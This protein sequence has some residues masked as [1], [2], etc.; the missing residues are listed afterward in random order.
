MISPGQKL[1]FLCQSFANDKGWMKNIPAVISRCW[2]GADILPVQVFKPRFESADAWV[3]FYTPADLV[4]SQI[5]WEDQVEPAFIFYMLFQRIVK[6][7]VMGTGKRISEIMHH[8]TRPE[9]ARKSIPKAW[10]ISL[11]HQMSAGVITVSLQICGVG[12]AQI[13]EKIEIGQNISQNKCKCFGLVQ[14]H[15]AGQQ[16][17]KGVM[18]FCFHRIPLYKNDV[19]DSVFIVSVNCV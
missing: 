16:F 14:E 4:R 5:V 7:F 11:I 1:I 19:S 8:L 3:R 15:S 10:R 12:A 9:P 18:I 13:G 6:F 2:G 17:W